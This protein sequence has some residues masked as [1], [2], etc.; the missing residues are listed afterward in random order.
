[1]GDV[2]DM[3]E[4]AEVGLVR[5]KIDAE[6][7]VYGLTQIELACKEAHARIDCSR[8]VA[9]VTLR[10]AAPLPGNYAVGD[11]IYHWL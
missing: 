7:A 11:L 6:S 9:A 3:D 5:A 10:K 8:R 2:F 4:F 1:M